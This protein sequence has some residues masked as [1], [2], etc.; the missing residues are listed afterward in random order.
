MRA[1]T[2]RLRAQAGRSGPLWVRR[3]NSF[4][5]LWLIPRLAG[6]TRAHPGIH[7]RITAETRVQNLERDG[8][9]VAL[10]HGPAALAG[11]EAVRLFGERVFPGCSPKVLRDPERQLRV[12]SEF[13]NHWF[14]P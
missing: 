13:E 14:L 9:D 3:T 2:E 1:A 8:L 11:P 6:F 4:A 12:P 5:A 10:R 7:V